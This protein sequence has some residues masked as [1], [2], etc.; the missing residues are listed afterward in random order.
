MNIVSKVE[1]RCKE[2]VF[3]KDLWGVFHSHQCS[4]NIWKDGYCK[5]H[6]PDTKKKR[7][8]EKDKR[9]K[10][11]QKQ[12]PWYKLGRAQDKIKR[13]EKL[14]DELLIRLCGHPSTNMWEE[15]KTKVQEE[16]DRGV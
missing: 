1:G 15:M 12:D 10:E 7:E 3:P 13:M 14:V 9:F 5:Q 4:R 8:K 6:H 16:R 2:K 11:K